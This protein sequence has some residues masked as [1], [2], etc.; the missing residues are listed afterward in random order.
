MS[1]GNVL[2]FPLGR[3]VAQFDSTATQVA[4]SNHPLCTH[5]GQ[6][7]AL[8][9]ITWYACLTVA[10][11]SSS[12]IGGVNGFQIVYTPAESGPSV[13][14]PA[15]PLATGQYN[16]VGTTIGSGVVMCAVVPGSQIGFSFGYSSTG[17][18]AAQYAMHVRVEY[19]GQS[20]PF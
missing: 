8:Y 17:A 10:A 11:T 3:S 20:S 15:S 13:T 14:S 16:M 5:Q 19:L 6:S 1:I 2:G 18:T 7:S 12:W 4:Y 9:R